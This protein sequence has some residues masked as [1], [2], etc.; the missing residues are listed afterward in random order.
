MFGAEIIVLMTF[1]FFPRKDDD[2][3]T[4]VSKSFEHPASS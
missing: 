4:F 1:G 2:F 3:S